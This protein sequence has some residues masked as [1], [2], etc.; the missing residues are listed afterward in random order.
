MT[1]ENLDHISQI[2]MALTIG[3]IALA[4]YEQRKERKLLER[5]VRRK[6]DGED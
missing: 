5:E 6:E 1:L 3:V 4:A 2:I